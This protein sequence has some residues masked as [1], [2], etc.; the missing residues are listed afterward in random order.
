M[1]QDALGQELERNTVTP[2]TSGESL[3]L[4]LDASVQAETEKVLAQVG[5]TYQPDGATAIVMNPRNQEVLAMANWP[6]VDPRDPAD[7]DPEALGNMATGF[8]Y[9][10]GSTFKAFTVAGALQEK[11]VTPETRFDLAPTIKVADRTIEESH[12]RGYVELL[13]RR[14]PQVLVER[15]RGHHRPQARRDG[16]RQVD[17]RLRLRRSRP[18]SSS[19]ARSR[20]S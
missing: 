18:A 13:D 5:R 17:P 9:E 1:I 15:R 11:L 4:S 6:G 14:D 20:G 8:S 10:P 3:Q 16:V 12:E 7:A 19:R 2:A